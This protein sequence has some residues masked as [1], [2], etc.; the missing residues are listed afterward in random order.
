MHCEQTVMNPDHTTRAASTE[1]FVLVFVTIRV[2]SVQDSDE[3]GRPGASAGSWMEPLYYV[4]EDVLVVVCGGE[5]GH[6]KGWRERRA[7]H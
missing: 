2:E 4:P 6:P 1:E 5:R 7:D 3:L